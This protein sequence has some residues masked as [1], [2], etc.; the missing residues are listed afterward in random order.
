MYGRLFLLIGLA[1]AGQATDPAVLANQARQALASGQFDKS[2]AIYRQLVA[3]LP[4]VAGM[5]L[6]LALALFQGGRHRDAVTELKAALKMQPDLAAASMML[7]MCYAKL[8][9]PV[10]AIPLL[11]QAYK[12]EPG[13]GPVLLELADSYFVTGRYALAV[14]RFKDLA[15]SQPKN[16]LA[17]RGLG[18]SLTEQS[19]V[20]FSKLPMGGAESLT[21]LA[22]AKLAQQEPKA[23]YSYLRQAVEKNPR[24]GPAH[25]LLAEL[26]TQTG[27]P[28]WAAAERAKAKS[29]PAA[30]GP[31]QQVVEMSEMALRSLGKLAELGPSAPLYE[32]EAEAARARGA[33][34]EAVA[35]LRKA[36]AMKPGQTR[37]EKLLARALFLNKEYDAAL[38]LLTKH[39]MKAELGEALLETGKPAEAIPYLAGSPGSLGRAYLETGEAAKAIAPLRAA[40]AGDSDGSV[41]FQLARALQRTGAAAEAREMDRLSQQLRQKKAQQSEALGAV[42]IRPF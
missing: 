4:D 25:A 40:L 20:V 27:H 22:R 6:N 42:E 29:L 13:N 2:A 41:H 1:A 35:A 3:Q 38:P 5:R 30:T 17:W 7:G 39:Q 26:Y 16:P 36:L 28:D 14:E 19:Q 33:Y 8:G 31:Y 18:L 12:R 9:E 11:E 32:T 24:F 23:A 15:F 21:L 10:A 37:Y 34:P